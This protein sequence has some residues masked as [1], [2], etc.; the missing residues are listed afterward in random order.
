MVDFC[1]LNPL[2]NSQ[3]FKSAS[4]KNFKYDF[5]TCREKALFYDFFVTNFL[6]KRGYLENFDSPRDSKNYRQML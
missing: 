6:D 5:L 3:I 4:P 2:R 1:T